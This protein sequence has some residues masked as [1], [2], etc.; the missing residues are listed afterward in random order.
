MRRR[1]LMAERATKRQQIIEAAGRCFYER[2][3]SAAGVDSIAAEADV[4]KRT[5]YN[6]FPS[7]DDLLLAYIVWTDVRWR[8]RLGR[9]MADVD[10]PIERVLVYFDG[11][12]E[13]PDHEEFRGCALINAAAEIAEP[14]S[15]VL[16]VLQ[17]HKRRVHV[18]IEELIREAGVA[19]PEATAASLVLLLEGAVA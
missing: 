17:S 6:H 5:L 3:I 1:G 4:S 13:V 7:K 10:D 11:Y 8:Q 14:D 16:A 19:D 12:F 15:P 2:G 9:L 18:E